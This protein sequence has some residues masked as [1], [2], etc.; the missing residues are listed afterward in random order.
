MNAFRRLI[1]AI[2]IA[3]TA[4]LAAG[5][6]SAHAA[7]STTACF[8]WSNNTAYANQPMQLWRTD[9]TGR[10]I[11][12]QRSGRTN[13]SG[14]GT[15]SNTPSNMYLRAVAQ[16]NSPAVYG[17]YDHWEGFS[18]RIAT[19]GSGAANLGTGYVYYVWSI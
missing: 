6:P 18:P 19:P 8:R 3:L 9:S 2:L 4:T 1:A 5:V 12:L 14:C 7:T 17:H 15:F 13:A 10:L 16:Y 11:S